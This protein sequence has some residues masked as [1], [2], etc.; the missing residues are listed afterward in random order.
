M[1]IKFTL[2]LFSILT[3]ASCAEKAI[4][5]E[6][7]NPTDNERKNEIISLF[8]SDISVQLL[9]NDSDELIILD[10]AGAQIPYQLI[11]NEQSKA[12]E[13][14]FST[15]LLGSQKK[16]YEIKKGSPEYFKILTHGRAVPERKDDF[17]WENDR[18]A[19]RMYGPALAAE[20]ASNG[21]DIWLK[22]TEE[23]VLEKFYSDELKNGISYHEDHGLGLDCYKVARTLG[24]GGIAPFVNDTLW[25]G[26]N[27]TSATLIDQ[28]PLRTSFRLVYE[29]AELGNKTYTQTLTVS[30]DAGSQMNKAIVSY[31]GDFEFLP[32]AAGI[33]LHKE[34]GI[35]NYD[36]DKKYIAYAENAVS[37]AGIHSGR[38]YVGLVFTNPLSEICQHS[39]HILGLSRYKKGREFTY[40]FG[41]GWSKWGFETDQEWFDY[42]EKFSQDIEMPLQVQIIK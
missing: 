7:S 6:V 40:Y 29:S 1:K 15:S 35:I 42:V 24:A 27:Y 17:A 28:G 13:I 23:L 31:D 37:D 5:V 11:F 4:K 25:V 16:T 33:W 22:R 19:F 32:I 30:L 36:I 18:I 38:N 39:E 14:I 12:Q 3:L 34:L 21:V 10:E 2:L 9:L 26:R 8:W 41:S 20:N